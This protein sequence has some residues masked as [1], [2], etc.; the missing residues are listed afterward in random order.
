MKASNKAKVYHGDATAD[1]SSHQFD[2]V[3]ASSRASIWPT[4][5]ST[6][7]TWAWIQSY[8]NIFTQTNW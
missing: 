2:N 8:K 3:P 4:Y 6:L 7:V 1:K 5:N